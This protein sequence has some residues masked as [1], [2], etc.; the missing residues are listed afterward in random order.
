MNFFKSDAFKVGIVAVMVLV[1]VFFM[2]DFFVLE[3]FSLTTRV[4]DRNDALNRKVSQILIKHK[5]VKTIIRQRLV[6][7]RVGAVEEYIKYNTFNIQAKE[8]KLI[9]ANIVKYSEMNDLPVPLTVAVIKALSAFNPTLI[10]NTGKRGLFQIKEGLIASGP[11]NTTDYRRKLHEIQFN[12]KIG[13]TFLKKSIN[14]AGGD[15]SAGIINFTMSK[16]KDKFLKQIT[17]NVLNYTVYVDAKV[18]KYEES[19]KASEIIAFATKQ[20]LEEAEALKQGK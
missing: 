2:I 7:E 20:L 4:Q 12:I 9:A 8:I 16:S 19:I 15:I 5:R 17:E 13:T 10:S 1:V 3:A 14:Q 18:R 6:F 11:A